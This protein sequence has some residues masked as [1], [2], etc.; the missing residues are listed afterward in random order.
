[1]VKEKGKEKDTSMVMC[2]NWGY[3]KHVEEK[4]NYVSS[5]TDLSEKDESLWEKIGENQEKPLIENDR[6]KKNMS[7]E[8]Q[9]KDGK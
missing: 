1:M 3:H 4:D 2:E 7:T 6:I 8:N 5:I 9:L